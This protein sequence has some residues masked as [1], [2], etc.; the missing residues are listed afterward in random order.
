MTII[1]GITDGT[2]VYI[3]GDRGASDGVTI[4]SLSRPKVYINNNW[5]FN[6]LCNG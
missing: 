1:V 6:R 2:K 4:L 5:I 3:G